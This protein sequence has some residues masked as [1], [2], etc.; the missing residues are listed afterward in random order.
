MQE[1][2]VWSLGREDPLE[3]ETATYSRILAWEVLWTEEPGRLQSMGSQKSDTTEQLKNNTGQM[4]LL[5]L[6]KR[7][8]LPWVTRLINGSVGSKTPKLLTFN[9]VGFSRPFLLGAEPVSNRVVGYIAVECRLPGALGDCPLLSPP[10]NSPFFPDNEGD[11][12]AQNP[13]RKY[14]KLG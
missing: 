13:V 3:E 7:H 14:N 5:R 8:A 1:T 11:P 9:W 4:R 10:E 12:W 2:W 6:Q